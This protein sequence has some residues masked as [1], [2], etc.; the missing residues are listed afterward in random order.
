MSDGLGSGI[1]R[2]LAIL[3]VAWGMLLLAFFLPGIRLDTTFSVCLYWLTG[4]AGVTGAILI[5]LALYVLRHTHH[6]IGELFFILRAR[7]ITCPGWR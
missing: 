6:H 3:L 4:T 5:G 7:D 1:A 2:S